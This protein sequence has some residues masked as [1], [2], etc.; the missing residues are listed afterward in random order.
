MPEEKEKF[1][2]N[3]IEPLKFMPVCSYKNVVIFLLVARAEQGFT[4]KQGIWKC[5]FALPASS[6]HRKHR[7]TI[8]IVMFPEMI[9]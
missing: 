1:F 2:Q 4:G 6:W 3:I 9:H 7:S 5:F 8:V